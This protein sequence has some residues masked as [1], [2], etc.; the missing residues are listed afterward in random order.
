M[1]RIIVIMMIEFFQ[2][3]NSQTNPP[4]RAFRRPPLGV[5]SVLKEEARFVGFGQVPKFPSPQILFFLF[6]A[7][8]IAKPGGV[9]TRPFPPAAP[10]IPPRIKKIACVRPL[11]QKVT[12]VFSNV[13]RFWATFFD[14]KFQRYFRHAFFQPFSVFA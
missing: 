6:L 4:T 7:R 11:G 9:L 2:V 1:I 8:I 3:A 14:I 5:P 12:T 13:Y 10:P